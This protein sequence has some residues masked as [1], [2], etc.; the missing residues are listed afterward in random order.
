MFGTG[1][2]KDVAGQLI[3]ITRNFFQNIGHT[4]D[5]HVEQYHQHGLC[6]CGVNRA[7]LATRFECLERLG[8]DE[9]DGDKPVADENEADDVGDRLLAVGIGQDQRGHE[10]PVTFAIETAR[11]LDFFH[12]GTRRQLQLHML[13]YTVQ[14]VGGRIEQI[15][16][17]RLRKSGL[18]GCSGSQAATFQ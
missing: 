6:A 2:V 9:A 7:S 5:N 11:Y 18:V 4:I 16:P 8:L 13:S 17:Q 15:E 12:V 3:D 1:G 10:S 14:L